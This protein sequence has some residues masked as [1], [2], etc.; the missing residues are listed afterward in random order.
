METR[1]RKLWSIS[2]LMISCAALIISVSNLLSV[3]LPDTILR[4]S[5]VICLVALP[6]LAYTSVKLKIWEK[7]DT[8]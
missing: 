4:I 8:E 3:K 1:L 2:L 7:R 5:G 6:V